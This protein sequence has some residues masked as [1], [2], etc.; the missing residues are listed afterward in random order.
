MRQAPSAGRAWSASG[1][2]MAFVFWAS[3]FHSP[4]LRFT[5]HCL[6]LRDFVRRRNSMNEAMRFFAYRNVRMS[7]RKRVEE[8]M[9]QSF[10]DGVMYDDDEI[11]RMLP[12]QL[13]DELLLDMY[14]TVLDAMPFVPHETD[15]GNG[16][17]KAE[18][19]EATVMP[20][21]AVIT[22]FPCVSLPFL[23]VP[24]RSHMTVALQSTRSGW[25]R[26]QTASAPTPSHAISLLLP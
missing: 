24:L 12:L 6:S 21:K 3:A 1:H 15:G 16:L 5:I 9:H 2:A 13:Q 18:N 19:G 14:C 4:G 11:I 8:Y 10:P 20:L 23:A 7:L 26:K 17:A 25:V 22:A